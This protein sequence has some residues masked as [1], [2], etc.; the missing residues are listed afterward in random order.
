M[1]TQYGMNIPM[2]FKCLTDLS[3]PLQVKAKGNG[4]LHIYIIPMELCPTGIEKSHTGGKRGIDLVFSVLNIHETNKDQQH[5]TL[6][7]DSVGI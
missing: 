6:H 7:P 4:L 5:H 1:E 2:G 3:F